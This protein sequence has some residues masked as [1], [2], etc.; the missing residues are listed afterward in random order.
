[1]SDFRRFCVAF[2]A[3]SLFLIVAE[4]CGLE[5]KYTGLAAT[6]ARFLI[7]ISFATTVVALSGR[8]A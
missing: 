8:R 4:M 1:M 5:G 2:V 3:A 7:A 6:H